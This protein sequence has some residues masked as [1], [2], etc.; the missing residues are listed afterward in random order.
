MGNLCSG[1]GADGQGHELT[2]DALADTSADAPLNNSAFVFIK[3]HAVTEKVEKLVREQLTIASI[4]VKQSGVIKAEQIDKDGLID[5]HYGAIASRAMHQLPTDL[6]VQDEAKEQ[7]KKI[8]QVEWQAALDQNKVFNAKDAAE[9]LGMKPLDLSKKFDTLERGKD[10]VKFGGG[11]YVGRIRTDKDEIYVVNGFYMGMRAKFTEPGKSIIFFEVCWDPD[12]LPW[13]KFRAEVIGAT[14]PKEADGGSIRRLILDRWES[15]GLKAEP[16]TGDNSVHASASPF[17]GLAERANWLRTDVGND[18][19]GR[20]LVAAGINE[21][22]I[23]EWSGDPA[24][25][26]EKKKQSLFDL[27][28]DLDARPCVS[29]AVDILAESKALKT[30]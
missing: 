7:F 27:L 12:G 10:Q 1:P 6:V 3:P 17:E 26:F 9:K 15:L 2:A 29:K 11:F 4:I 14:N 23:K 19:F 8:F 22:T 28:E 5:K 30:E 18:A 16:N 13:K 20:A 25:E 24:V 21:D